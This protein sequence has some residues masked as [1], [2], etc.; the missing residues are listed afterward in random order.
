MH[1][2]C[3]P[4]LHDYLHELCCI[5]KEYST[6]S[7]GEM[8]CVSDPTELFKAVGFDMEDLKPTKQKTDTKYSQARTSS[9]HQPNTDKY[10]S[11]AFTLPALK[12]AI[13]KWQTYIQHLQRLERPLPQKP[14]PTPKPFTPHQPTPIRLLSQTPTPTS[15][16]KCS[17]PSPP[18]KATHLSSAKARN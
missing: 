2:A 16:A 9:T 1:Y 17:P 5:L 7:V 6:F 10:A 3:G 11:Q 4:K 15:P 18:S 14:Q 12:R 13:S 8:P